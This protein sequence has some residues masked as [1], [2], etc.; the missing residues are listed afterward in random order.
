MVRYKKLIEEG[1]GNPK[2]SQF[3]FGIQ[4]MNEGIKSEYYIDSR[5]KRNK[6]GL[7][8]V[9]PFCFHNAYWYVCPDCGKLHHTFNFGKQLS[10][11]C[12]PD[13]NV[14]HQ[15]V[16]KEH[17]MIKRNLIIVVKNTKQTT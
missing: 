5:T 7:F 4:V 2:F 12:L 13:E 6:Q 14:R 1:S 8:E 11:C 3:Y 16:N 15:Y 17:Y 9:K 10:G